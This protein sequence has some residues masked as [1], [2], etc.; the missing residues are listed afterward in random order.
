M[1]WKWR[2]TQRAIVGLILRDLASR[3]DLKSSVDGCYE[4]AKSKMKARQGIGGFSRPCRAK[5]AQIGVGWRW[6]FLPCGALRRTLARFVPSCS[7]AASVNHAKEGQ[8]V[9]PPSAS[10]IGCL[11]GR[12]RHARGA[13]CLLRSCDN[14][15]SLT[16]RLLARNPPTF[17][18]GFCHQSETI[19]L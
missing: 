10:P 2:R 9:W 16:S 15:S 4:R 14:G 19:R 1:R 5:T 8:G 11:C 6:L 13:W 18:K 17:P 12:S 3:A 7:R